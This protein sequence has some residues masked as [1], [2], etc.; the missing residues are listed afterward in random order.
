MVRKLLYQSLCVC[1]AF[2]TLGLTSFPSSLQMDVTASPLKED[3][4][5]G[6]LLQLD[7]LRVSPF[8]LSHTFNESE[9]AFDDGPFDPRGSVVFTKKSGLL[10]LWNTRTG[11]LMR[12]L[13]TH[14]EPSNVSFNS[15]GSSIIAIGKDKKTK[16]ITTELWSAD[17]N[18]LKA[19]F[20][21]VIIF[22]PGRIGSDPTVVLTIH[23][24][25]VEFWNGDTGRLIKV[26]EAYQNRLLNDEYSPDGRLVV[27]G[28]KKPV[29]WET[30]SGKLRAELEL[31]RDAPKSSDY[32][33]RSLEIEKEKFSP[34]GQTVVT[35]DSF[36]RIEL[37]DPITGKLRAIL[38]GHRDS[39]YEIE[40]SNDGRLLATASR[41]G[42]A[43]VWD[44]ST[45]QLKHTF[46]AGKQIA[47]RVTFSP[48]D[49]VL[50]V[51]YQNQARLWNVNTGQLIGELSEDK[52]ISSTTLLGTYLHGIE[53]RFR[54]D[55]NLLLTESDKTVKVWDAKTGKF[56][57]TL[58]N[59]RPPMALSSNGK[60]LA[61]AG[62]DKS[63]L[64]WE[65][66]AR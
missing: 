7:P 49:T 60:Y 66:S 10:K 57:A 44:V 13:D 26:V 35:V 65:I 32:T 56:I 30:D 12:T 62:P 45:G 42:T 20:D 29:L 40:F 15:D 33:G 58:E 19:T 34:D 21:G 52:D 6:P 48:S 27:R 11:E 51:G 64:L 5:N 1:F 8:T 4:P 14:Q 2:T 28:G 55:G 24:N 46:K 23:K 39:I 61:T 25:E 17:S 9:I 43:R 3:Q 47:R 50:A 41:D 38:V 22:G 37:W 16:R 63:V 53:L 36:N 18:A 31:P 54:P 59:A